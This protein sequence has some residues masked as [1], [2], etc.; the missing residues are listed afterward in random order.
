[1]VILYTKLV[2]TPFQTLYWLL[3]K[4]VSSQ[5]LRLSSSDREF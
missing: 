1:M 2:N 5:I 3:D 4:W